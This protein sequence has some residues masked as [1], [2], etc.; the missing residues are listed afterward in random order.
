MSDIHVWH[1][2]VKQ[3]LTIYSR[4]DPLD[5]DMALSTVP[6]FDE[7][8]RYLVRHGD[9]NP[10]KMLSGLYSTTKCPDG[11]SSSWKWLVVDAFYT[12][13]GKKETKMFSVISPTKLWQVWWN[14]AHSF[15][16][17]FA[18]TWYKRF[19]PHLNNVSTLPCE[20]WN[21]HRAR[22]TIACV[23]R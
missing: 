5:V 1:L 18:A 14:L 9:M 6:H 20:T 12:V 10:D 16:N 7:K 11:I 4:E 2:T 17:K 19:P 8:K 22:A 15:Q 3:K 13:S 21:A 23:V